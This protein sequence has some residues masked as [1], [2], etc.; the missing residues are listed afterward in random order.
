MLESVISSSLAF[1]SVQQRSSD[2]F[3][4]DVI[5]IVATS[6]IVRSCAIHVVSI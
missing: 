6:E 2:L 4:E 5:E 3:S 1:R